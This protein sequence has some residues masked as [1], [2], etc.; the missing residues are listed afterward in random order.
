MDIVVK[1]LDLINVHGFRYQMGAGTK[2]SFF[3]GIN[4]SSSVHFDNEKRL[5]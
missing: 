4:N 3:F 5:S 1:V 2:M